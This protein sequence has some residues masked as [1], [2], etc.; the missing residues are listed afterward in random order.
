[1]KPGYGARFQP[2]A[3]ATFDE[4]QSAFGLQVDTLVTESAHDCSYY[5]TMLF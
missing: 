4:L 3:T 1:M 5:L 2:V